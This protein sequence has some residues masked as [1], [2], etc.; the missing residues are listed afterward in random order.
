MAYV[1]NV[2]HDYLKKRDEGAKDEL[3]DSVKDCIKFFKEDDGDHK[4][5]TDVDELKFEEFYDWFTKGGWVDDMIK[6][7][8]KKQIRKEFDKQTKDPDQM[9]LALKEDIV[10]DNGDSQEEEIEPDYDNDCFI[11]CTGSKFNVSCFGKHIGVFV[12]Q[13]DADAAIKNCLR[14]SPNFSP[15][16]WFVSDHGNISSYTLD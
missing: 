13:E 10:N 1:V 6:S 15:S 7:Y 14:G 5:I 2:M 9:K 4:H 3:S 12:E 16:I 8:S 11:E